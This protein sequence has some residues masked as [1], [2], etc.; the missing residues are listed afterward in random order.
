MTAPAFKEFPSMLR[1]PEKSQ[2]PLFPVAGTGQCLATAGCG[3][4]F[5]LLPLGE[6]QTRDEA[7][8]PLLGVL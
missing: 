1:E 2:F 3:E 7:P 6:S 4:H 8:S 5:S